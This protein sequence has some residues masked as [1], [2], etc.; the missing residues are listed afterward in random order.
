MEIKTKFTIGEEVFFI[1]NYLI[2]SDKIKSIYTQHSAKNRKFIC[3]VFEGYVTDRKEYELF[4]TEEGA[5]AFLNRYNN[6]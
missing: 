3:Y 6:E 2:C 1:A 4:E 5:E